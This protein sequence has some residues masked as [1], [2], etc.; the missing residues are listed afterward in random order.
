MNRWINNMFW[1][2]FDANKGKMPTKANEFFNKMIILNFSKIIVSKVKFS[3]FLLFRKKLWHTFFI[4]ILK[5]L[6]W[7]SSGNNLNWW[8]SRTHMP[9]FEKRKKSNILL[10]IFIISLLFTFIFFLFT[11]RD[12]SVMPYTLW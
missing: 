2:D 4:S 11:E 1:N 5:L 3:Y 12:F 9:S 6:Y 8:H 10:F 7:F